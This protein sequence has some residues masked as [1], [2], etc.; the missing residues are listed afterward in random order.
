MIFA[1]APSGEIVFISLTA[2]VIRSS[3]RETMNAE[4]DQALELIR[5]KT[6]QILLGTITN[7]YERRIVD[8]IICFAIDP[9]NPRKLWETVRNVTI[10]PRAIGAT[11]AQIDNESD[12]LF[13]FVAKRHF[14]ELTDL[15]I[16][17][18]Q[19]NVPRI[20][21]PSTQLRSSSLQ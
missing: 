16:N 14:P 17:E 7:I 1:S 15:Q 4:V 8:Y 12:M 11:K 5:Q 2:G 10:D 21:L 6:P 19:R 20:T 13:N 18:P 9:S 3:E